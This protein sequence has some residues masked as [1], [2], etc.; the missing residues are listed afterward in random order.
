MIKDSS[1]MDGTGTSGDIQLKEDLQKLVFP[2]GVYYNRKTQRFTLKF[3]LDNHFTAY[4][5]CV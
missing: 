2:E 3:I 5:L 1:F 4:Y